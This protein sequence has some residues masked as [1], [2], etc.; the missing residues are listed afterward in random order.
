MVNNLLYSL[1]A[2]RVVIAK[3]VLV[4]KYDRVCSSVIS[5]KY[6]DGRCEATA[7]REYGVILED[8]TMALKKKLNVV[9][10]RKL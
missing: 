1:V 4:Q 6:L 9:A 10:S 7:T 5:I 2:T 3:S 8:K